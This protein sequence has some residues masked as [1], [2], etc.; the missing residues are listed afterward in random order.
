MAIEGLKISVQS[1]NAVLSWPSTNT[2]T[3]VIQY[4]SNLTAS[5]SWQT[6]TDY[7]PAAAS[8]NITLFVNSNSVIYLSAGYGGTNSGGSINPTN[9]SSGGGTNVFA[10]TSG[11]YQVVRDG[12]HLW[13]ITNGMVVSNVLV[14]SIEIATTNTDPIAGIVLY[15]ANT[16]SPIP[17]ASVENAGGNQWLLVWNTLQSINNTYE[18][19]AEV[20]F[21][22]NQ[23]ALSQPVSVT[24]NNVISFPNYFSQ[25][26]GDQMWIYAATIPNAGYQ[27]DVYDS[28][29]NYLGSFTGNADSTGTISFV[30][31]LVD[32]NGIT[33]T[34]T[35]FFGVF[36]VN[37]SGGP[38]V[39]SKLPSLSV[40]G[41]H[42]QNASPIKKAFSTI[43]QN[44]SPHPDAGSSSASATQLWTKE[45]AW[46][47]NNNW[48]V[49]YGL[50]NGQTGESPQNDQYMIAGG[51]GGEYGGVLGTLD[52]YGL[53]GNISPG[54]NEQGGNVFTLQDSTSR[55]QL[56]SYLGTS[57]YENFY[58]FGH[59][60][61]SSIGSYNGF[62]LTQDQI[63]YALGNVPLTMNNGDP[64]FDGFDPDVPTMV[65]PVMSPSIVHAA[66]HPYRFIYIDAC[67][68]GQGNFCQAFGV[69]AMTVNT[70]FFATAGVES[71]AFVGFQSWKLNLNFVSWQGYS[72]LTGG[73]LNDWESG[74]PVQS[75]VLNAQNDVHGTGANMDSSA[76]IYGAVDLTITTRTRP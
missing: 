28:N 31:D 57:T 46:T 64:V 69:P 20:D 47:P 52:G 51:P 72:L 45:G 16:L 1:T 6:L 39:V 33:H 5:S 26:F 65:Q 60:N 18:L 10:S 9:T 44:N 37:T 63:A 2:E 56:L 43:P 3:Y 36:T 12:A 41:A 27:I 7:F 22:S 19:C 73:F 13:G 61:N 25:D 53:N 4:R 76:I 74:V 49:A 55:T 48:V 59:G 70:N 38:A 17:G 34:D 50:F 29:T 75:C 67:N 24:V 30:W 21:A 42:F 11:F 54:N 66:L 71:R 68:T 14:T 58:F 62:Y 40:S 8:G 15:D 35:N 23:P 32:G